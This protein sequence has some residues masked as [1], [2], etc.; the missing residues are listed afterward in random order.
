MTQ[1]SM[2][3]QQQM[4]QNPT[5]WCCQR[6]CGLSHSRNTFICNNKLNTNFIDGKFGIAVAGMVDIKYERAANYKVCS[7]GRCEACKATWR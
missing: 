4:K 3:A 6:G 7:H 2:M 1:R 5:W